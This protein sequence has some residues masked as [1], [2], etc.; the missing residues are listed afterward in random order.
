MGWNF[1][2]SL[3]HSGLILYKI[4]AAQWIET[5]QNWCCTV[6]WYHM[7]STC[8]ISWTAKTT[9][10]KSEWKSKWAQWNAQAERAVWSQRMSERFKWMKKQMTQYSM[11][12]F[13]KLS[14]H[15]DCPI[16]KKNSEISDFDKNYETRCSRKSPPH[17]DHLRWAG[18]HHHLRWGA[19]HPR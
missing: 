3:L 7:K 15:R 14:T 5:V 16:S 6:G 19:Q 12:L 8:V 4:E 11:R 13:L 10:L 17:L 9:F 2:K 18:Q 1:I